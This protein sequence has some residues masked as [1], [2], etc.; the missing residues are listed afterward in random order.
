MSRMTLPPMSERALRSFGL[1]AGLLLVLIGAAGALIAGRVL[2]VL[3]AAA[4]LPVTLAVMR[5]WSLRPTYRLWNR[6]ARRYATLAAAWVIHVAYRIG[7]CLMPRDGDEGLRV[8]RV[9]EGSSAWVARD[10]LPAD[11]YASMA[12]NRGPL[13]KRRAGEVEYVN[14]AAR[15]GGAAAILIPLMYLLRLFQPG[16]DTSAVPSTQNYTLY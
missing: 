9:P 14:H 15:A 10:T 13:A 5:P 8:Q 4:V 2:W 16:Q 1:A 3:A 7:V 6:I 12:W 11:R